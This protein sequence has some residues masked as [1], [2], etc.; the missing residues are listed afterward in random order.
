[1]K[2]AFEKWYMEKMRTTSRNSHTVSTQS[3]NKGNIESP[4]PLTSTPTPQNM[5]IMFQGYRPRVRTSFDP[6][7]EIPLLQGW[8]SQNQHPSR[9]Q[10]LVY[11]GKLNA[12]RKGR[13][14]LDLTNIIYWFKNARA[15]LRKSQ[16]NGS[17]SADTSIDMTN[18]DI[19]DSQS[20]RLSPNDNE[21]PEVPP[22]LPNKNAVYV[23]SDPMHY[24][25]D[26]SVKSPADDTY[27]VTTDT[28]EKGFQSYHKT[29]GEVTEKEDEPDED[30]NT[31]GTGSAEELS[32]PG[33]ILPESK[34]TENKEE[35]VSDDDEGNEKS[36]NLKVESEQ[37]YQSSVSSSNRS[38]PLSQ[39]P[40]EIRPPP[41]LLTN[42]LQHQLNTSV[43]YP[44]S[45]PAFHPMYTS[46]A[47]DHSRDKYHYSPMIS[48][49]PESE[50]SAEEIMI[51]KKRSRVFIDP[52]S[53]IPKLEKWFLED[54]HPSSFMIEKYVDELNRAEYR[55]RFPKLEAKNVQLWF[56]NHRAK[57]KRMRIGETGIKYEPM[58]QI[59]SEP[60][61]KS[62]ISVPMMS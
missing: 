25:Q 34:N 59:K 26:L 13:K 17:R 30:Q 55:H 49:K 32:E 46:M 47:L 48:P 9:E 60:P 33:Q 57:V 37:G 42:P 41:P 20:G 23:V 22:E 1:M 56:K 12:L 39:S 28:R 6:E 27:T 29:T 15:A 53:E 36:L 21:T 52:L 3:P 38:S 11:M 44:H 40:T 50:L 58:E 54:T 5:N 14:P 10:M 45:F 31:S 61:S 16:T 18:G 43:P 35:H 8:F 4:H 24:P 19:E 51:R 2:Q 7:I 62:P